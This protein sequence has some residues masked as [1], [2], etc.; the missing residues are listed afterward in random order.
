MRK[1]GKMKTGIVYD[2]KTVSVGIEGCGSGG[3]TMPH[4]EWE[5][6]RM[7]IMR[8]CQSCGTC[9]HAKIV[10][11]SPDKKID[12]PAGDMIVREPQRKCP[13]WLS[14]VSDDDRSPCP[15][16]KGKDIDMK[17]EDGSFFCQ[18]R[19]CLSRSGGSPDE[20]MALAKWNGSSVRESDV[21][22]F[23]L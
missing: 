18:C 2:R 12:F 9:D 15:F 5:S 8:E 22:Y 10:C 4:D 23:Y 19:D 16:C 20:R 7:T 13:G 17:E 14:A 1:G 3:L 21:P 11:L 6:F